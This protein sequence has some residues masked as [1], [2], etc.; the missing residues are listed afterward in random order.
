[1]SSSIS[2]SDRRFGDG[3]WRRFA[4]FWAV[5]AAALLSVMLA[6]AY[7]VDPYDSGRSSLLGRPGV[8]PQG[9]RT[10][11]ASRGRDPRFNAAVIG[12]SHI[13]LIS[14]ER[15]DARTGLSFVQLSVPATGPKEQ[16]V[17]IDWFA[18]HHREARGLVIGADR[19]WCTADPSLAEDRPFPFWLYSRNRLEY[20]RGLLRY[21]VLEEVA[22]RVAYVLAKRPERARPD[23]YWDYEPLYRGMDYGSDPALRARLEQR[24]SDDYVPNRTGRFPAADALRVALRGLDPDVAVAIVF[25]PVYASLLPAAGTPGAIALRACKKA[26][27]TVAAERRLTAVVDWD[28]DRPEAHDPELFFDQT[29][30]RRPLATLLERDIASALE[31][32]ASALR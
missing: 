13:Q 20:A 32:Q 10:A 7:A 1:M 28:D 23:G 21:D 30:Y 4:G 26:F 25:P 2:N 14:P 5:F 27:Q 3:A 11:G 12:N 17:L 22:R 29:H 16:L 15:L 6:A 24:A 18:R 9:P 31:P 19:L 8:R